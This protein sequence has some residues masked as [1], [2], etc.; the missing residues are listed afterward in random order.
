MKQYIGE[1]DWAKI[2]IILSLLAAF[3]FG[4]YGLAAYHDR[5]SLHKTKGFEYRDL[6]QTAMDKG[7]YCSAERYW[8]L[9]DDS[10]SRVY[11]KTDLEDDNGLHAWKVLRKSFEDQRYL[12]SKKCL[13]Q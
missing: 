1:H 11:Y 8:S 6:A 3:C 4:A 13:G 10:I 7:H 2:A 9:A 12:C 5:I